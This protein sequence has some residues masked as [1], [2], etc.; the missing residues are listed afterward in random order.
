MCVLAELGREW[1]K[2]FQL[3]QF[4][5]FLSFCGI[6]FEIIYAAYLKAMFHSALCLLNS[7]E[8]C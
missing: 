4:C 5:I 3:R 7:S 1:K 6:A 2:L 8:D